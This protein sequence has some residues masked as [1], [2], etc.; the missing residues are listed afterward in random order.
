MSRPTFVLGLSISLVCL[1]GFALPA[2]AEGPAGALRA[3][4]PGAI[5]RS[6]QSFAGG[7]MKKLGKAEVASQQASRR[8][9]AGATYTG[10]ADGFSTEIKRRGGAYVGLR[11]YYEHVYQCTGPGGKGC[12]A[13]STVP[14]TEIFRFKNG[15]WIY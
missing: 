4:V 3:P 13:I 8:G 15:R 12:R 5:E 7:W 10:Y 6:M 14:V 1:A 2:L 11:R 9:A